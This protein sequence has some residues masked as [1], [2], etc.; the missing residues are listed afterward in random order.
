[1]GAFIED[2]LGQQMLE[3]AFVETDPRRTPNIAP[4]SSTTIKLPM[5]GHIDGHDP[6]DPTSPAFARRFSRAPV[7]SESYWRLRP[8][9]VGAARAVERLHPRP[10]PSAPGTSDPSPARIYSLL[11]RLLGIRLIARTH[12]FARARV[13]RDCWLCFT[14]QRHD[15]ARHTRARDALGDPRFARDGPN[16]R[17]KNLARFL[18]HASRKRARATNA[19]DDADERLCWALERV[20]ADPTYPG[21]C[22]GARASALRENDGGGTR[23]AYA[24]GSSC[25]RTGMCVLALSTSLREMGDGGGGGRG[26]AGRWRRG[27]EAG[28]EGCVHALES[29]DPAPVEVKRAEMA[30]RMRRAFGTIRGRESPEGKKK[31]GRRRRR[32]WKAMA[33]LV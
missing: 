31:G 8:G 21:R 11:R 16:E 10:S 23:E 18:P 5:A 22:Q 4:S 9:V 29:D 28:M 27:E 33:F 7:R 1:M 26:G 13:P 6:I 15:L 30:A 3:D 19:D 2:T 32:R 12:S 25:A 17:H 20:V 14:N 24:R